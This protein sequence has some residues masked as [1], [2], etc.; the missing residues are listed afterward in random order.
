[1][2]SPHLARFRGPGVHGRASQARLHASAVVSDPDGMTLPSSPE[3]SSIV[4]TSTLVLRARVRAVLGG[5]M[6][7]AHDHNKLQVIAQLPT[8]RHRLCWLHSEIS[9]GDFTPDLLS[10]PPAGSTSAVGTPT[11]PQ[12]SESEAASRRAAAAAA[13]AVLASAFPLKSRGAPVGAS[14]A[15]GSGGGSA[16]RTPR[17]AIPLVRLLQALLSLLVASRSPRRKHLVCPCMVTDGSTAVR[18]CDL[19]TNAVI[20]PLPLL[21]S[22]ATYKALHPSVH[23]ALLCRE[24]C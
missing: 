1:M 24:H 6:S 17:N 2:R 18:T 23:T 20:R 4:I 7:T 21:L 13:D 9:R 3:S 10:V 11:P 12:I 22:S 16:L 15:H 19:R 5:H 14:D 8:G